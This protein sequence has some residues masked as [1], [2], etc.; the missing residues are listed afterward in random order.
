MVDGRGL[1]GLV[2]LFGHLKIRSNFWVVQC[3]V[4]E[5]P[6]IEG[7]C[8]ADGTNGIQSVCILDH[9]QFCGSKDRSV[10]LQTVFKG[11]MLNDVHHMIYGGDIY[12]LGFQK[13]FGQFRA[14]GFVPIMELEV[15]YTRSM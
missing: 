11:H 1:G 14:N 3:P 13:R 7:T 8:N 6:I 2:L 9:F 5:S 10:V 4:L 12:L 15:L